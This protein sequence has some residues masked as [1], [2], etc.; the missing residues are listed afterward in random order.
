MHHNSDPLSIWGAIATITFA[1]IGSLTINE[2]A[3]ITAVATG[4]VTMGYTIFKW[5]KEANNKK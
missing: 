1:F 4:L 3:G 5:R 2:W